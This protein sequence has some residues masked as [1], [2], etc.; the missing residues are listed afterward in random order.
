MHHATT[1][2]LAVARFRDL[3]VQ[4]LADARPRRSWCVPSLHIRRVGRATF[5]STLVVA[6]GRWPMLSPEA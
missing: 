5:L 2:G 4:R 6:D 3:P 1:G